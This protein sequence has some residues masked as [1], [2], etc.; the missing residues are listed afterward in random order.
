MDNLENKLRDVRGKTVN[1]LLSQFN[2]LTTINKI[3]PDN[4]YNKNFNDRTSVSN[5]GKQLA[6]GLLND[7]TNTVRDATNF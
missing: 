1:G 6:S 3:E 7:L 4:V 2:N 5:F